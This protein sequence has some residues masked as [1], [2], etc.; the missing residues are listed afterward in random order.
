MMKEQ[1]GFFFFFFDRGGLWKGEG[2][3]P[4]KAMWAA[5]VQSAKQLSLPSDGCICRGSEAPLQ[6]VLGQTG[7]Q[8]SLP[9]S[10]RGNCESKSLQGTDEPPAPCR[11]LPF[12]LWGKIGL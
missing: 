4:L 2:R 9:C 1:D 11:L 6:C 8:A 10:A 7:L 3:G 12:P 5:R